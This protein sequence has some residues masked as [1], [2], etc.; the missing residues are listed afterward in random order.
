M[1]K[2]LTCYSSS[3]SICTYAEVEK[4][5]IFDINEVPGACLD[6]W[7]DLHQQYRSEMSSALQDNDKESKNQSAEVV[8]RKYKKVNI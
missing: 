5:P 4:L 6:K 2:V 7:E 1:N 3:I 8:I